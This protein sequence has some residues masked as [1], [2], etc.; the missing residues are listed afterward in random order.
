MPEVP[1]NMQ[2]NLAN[3]EL[4]AGRVARGERSVSS[5]GA[6][7][8]TMESHAPIQPVSYQ[9]L[10]QQAPSKSGYT[11]SYEH[12]NAGQYQNI[13]N[14]NSGQSSTYDGA[15][16]N[17]PPRSPKKLSVFP[18]PQ[19]AGQNVP[20]SDDEKEAVLERARPKVMISN[21]PDMQL[22]WAQDA[23]QWVEISERDRENDVQ[24]DT[25]IP[26]V[27]QRIHQ[28]AVEIVKFLSD[29][30]HPKAEFIRGTW[31]EF[32]KHNYPIDKKEA[33]LCYKRAANQE[34]HGKNASGRAE[35]RM[36]WLFE[37]TK[38]MP[39]AISHY[40][41]GADMGDSASSYRLGMMTL[42][43]EHGQLKDPRKGLE[44]IRFAA[45]YADENAPQGAYMY[46]M[47]LAREIS[48]ISVPD[49]ILPID[50]RMAKNYIEKAAYLGFSKAQ[51]KMGQAYELCQ[52]GVEFDPALSLHYN[53]LAAKQGEAESDMAISKW[54][55][56]GHEG[57]FEKNE[58]QA[59]VFASRA[60]Q[61]EMPTAEFAIGYFYEI[62]MFSLQV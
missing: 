19:N 35:Y 39:K 12:T 30:G 60:A 16:Y 3:L 22:A 33:F 43:G 48:S 11:A 17:T 27:E 18:K 34:T 24:S 47:L 29:Q 57:V 8:S 38:E 26:L 51:L 55:L 14:R 59:F 49:D 32:G 25:N 13:N 40:Q 54:F 46:G 5:G 23:L 36:G 6:S 62:G 37:S 50:I 9:R 44:L 56:C 45:D 15:S 2:E 58:E 61:T 42:L 31:M 10:G 28:D 21:D 41:R 52:L 20:M 1:A 4:G 53:A 7:I